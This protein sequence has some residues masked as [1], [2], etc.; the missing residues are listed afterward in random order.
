MIETDSEIHA[1]P[2]RN[3]DGAEGANAIGDNRYDQRSGTKDYAARPTLEAHIGNQRCIGCHGDQELRART[4]LGD[5]KIAGRGRNENSGNETARQT[6][7]EG[8][9]QY[10]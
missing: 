5:F 9:C 1:G 8:V 2:V 10:V 4:S 7:W 6:W 3:I